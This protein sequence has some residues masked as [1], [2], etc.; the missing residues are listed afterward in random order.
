MMKFNLTYYHHH[1]ETKEVRPCVF[2]YIKKL[3][4]KFPSFSINQISF[5]I[6]SV[7]CSSNKFVFL[8]LVC[9]YYLLQEVVFFFVHIVKPITQKQ[10]DNGSLH[11]SSLSLS[12]SLS[13]HIYIRVQI[14]FFSFRVI[15]HSRVQ[16]S[17]M[18][19]DHKYA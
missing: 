5:S 3:K 1:Y 11:L 14:C 12:L 15:S 16:F 7:T 2:F 6:A 17:G 8:L 9:F 13:L 19:V 18:D 4:R 10:L